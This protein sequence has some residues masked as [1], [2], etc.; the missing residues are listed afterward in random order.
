MSLS[1]AGLRWA[2]TD[3]SRS[4]AAPQRNKLAMYKLF[5]IEPAM[6]SSFQVL[7]PR[8]QVHDMMDWKEKPHVALVMRLHTF[9]A[10]NNPR[11]GLLEDDKG[12]Y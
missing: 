7:K 8:S 1:C 10:S 6:I 11:E 5:M 2:S 3:V 9:E 12:W 4:I